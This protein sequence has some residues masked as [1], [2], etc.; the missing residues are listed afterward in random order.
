MVVGDGLG[1]VF[2]GSASGGKTLHAS[3]SEEWLKSSIT[4]VPISVTDPC[5]ISTIICKLEM[6]LHSVKIKDFFLK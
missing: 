6:Q 3:K 4:A 5:V 2:M 1:V